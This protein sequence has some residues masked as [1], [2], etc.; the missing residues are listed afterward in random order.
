MTTIRE[1]CEQGIILDFVRR[2]WDA[3]KEQVPLCCFETKGDLITCTWLKKW[4]TLKKFHIKCL[5]CQAEIAKY[6]KEHDDKSIP[7]CEE[8]SNG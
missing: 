8:D 4:Y 7:S 2:H 5:Q 1:Y 6:L 3:N